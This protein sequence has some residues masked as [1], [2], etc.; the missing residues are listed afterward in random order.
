MSL[1]AKK[2]LL[3]P[4]SAAPLQV[5]NTVSSF[6]EWRQNAYEARKSVGL[7]ATMGALHEGHLSLGMNPPL[8]HDASTV[9]DLLKV[10]RSL[11]ENDLTVM[12]IFVNPAQFAPNEDLANYPRT[13]PEDLRVLTALSMSVP[14]PSSPEL[15][16]TRRASAVFVPTASEMYPSGISQ[17]V[18][19]Q[20]GTFVEVKG[21]GHQ[22]EGQ[23][24]PTFFRGV[25]TVVT[26]LFNVIEVIRIT[27]SR[28][29]L[30]SMIPQCS[31]PTPILVKRTYNKHCYSGDFA[32]IF[33]SPIQIPN[34]SI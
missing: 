20:R 34:I 5:F 23:S 10:R 13:L 25:A 17:D 19:A 8:S 2:E 27:S 12:S 21:Y 14:N 7:V 29:A 16:V 6:R 3:L 18:R 22:M 9:F 28:Y 26:K 1:A 32:K 30:I 33:Y 11:A 4:A 15:S 31:Q 24:R